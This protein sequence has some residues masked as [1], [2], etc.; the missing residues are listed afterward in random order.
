MDK[1]IHAI[2]DK[3]TNHD[4]IINAIARINYD[5]IPTL[6]T[7]ANMPDLLQSILDPKK[8]Y[9]KEFHKYITHPNEIFVRFF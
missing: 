2:T 1:K 3:H 9:K 8:G 4:S 6:S 7:R 5:T